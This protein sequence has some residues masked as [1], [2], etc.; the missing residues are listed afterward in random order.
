MSNFPGR[1]NVASISEKL[2]GT[3]CI[4]FN[5]NEVGLRKFHETFIRSEA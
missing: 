2:T 4:Y 5:L 1:E 3:D